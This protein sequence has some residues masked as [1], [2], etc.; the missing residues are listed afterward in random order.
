MTA[1]RPFPTDSVATRGMLLGAMDA[2]SDTLAATAED[3][4]LSATLAPAAVE[5]LDAADRDVGLAAAEAVAAH[6]Y[7]FRGTRMT[8]ASGRSRCGSSAAVGARNVLW[9]QK[10]RRRAAMELRS[11]VG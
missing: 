10:I 1:D 8:S 5:A 9:E 3:S 7:R 11:S 4:D 2:I 6:R